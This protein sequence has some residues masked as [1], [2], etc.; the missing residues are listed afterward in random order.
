MPDLSTAF[1][2]MMASITSPPLSLYEFR[3]FISDDPKAQNALAFCEWYQ[4]YRTVYFDRVIANP[5]KPVTTNAQSDLPRQYTAASKENIDPSNPDAHAGQTP[6]RASF[7]VPNFGTRMY[8]GLPFGAT[9]TLK[10]HSF[11]VLSESVV[12]S[13]FYTATTSTGYSS[14]SAKRPP[15]GSSSSSAWMPDIRLAGPINYCTGSDDSDVTASRAV[16]QPYTSNMSTILRRRTLP[17]VPNKSWLEHSA[18]AQETNRLQIQSLLVYECWARFLSSRALEKVDIPEAELLYVQERLPLNVTHMPQPL[19]CRNDMIESAASVMAT[20]AGQHLANNGG[21]TSRR[22]HHVASSSDV[23]APL[24]L[25]PCRSLQFEPQKQLKRRLISRVNM[26]QLD[27]S[28]TQSP[29]SLGFGPDSADSVFPFAYDSASINDD[30]VK[31][32]IAGLRRISTMPALKLQDT[33]SKTMY[34]GDPPPSTQQYNSPSVMRA[35]RLIPIAELQMYHRTL[36]PHPPLSLWP[37]NSPTSAHSCGYKPVPGSLSKLISSNTV[38]PAVFDTVAKISANYLLQSHFPGFY[39]QAHYNTTP[40][41]RVVLFIA[42]ALAFLSGFGI[43]AALV[44]LGSS[45]AWRVASTY[46]YKPFE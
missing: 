4:R 13:A 29:I 19:L 32:L 8:N 24:K 21:T 11:S 25:A 27:V 36:R 42:A 46:I 45:K 41:E 34:Q 30:S 16:R 7:S 3:L 44:V 22:S 5:T 37:V 33:L 1:E 38:P 26:R 35:A 12:D 9:H 10:S 18:R 15:L 14:V 31:Q 28:L 43:A 17:P 40:N 20:C 2:A 39:R 6:S 23:S